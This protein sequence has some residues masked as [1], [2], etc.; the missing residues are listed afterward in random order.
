MD[1]QLKNKRSL[2]TGSTAGIG[3]AIAEALAREGAGV[4][5]N[6]RS[7]QSVDGAI[8]RLQPNVSGKLTGFAGDLSREDIAEKLA[9]EHPDIEILV[10]SL[11]IF[12]PVPFEQ[13]ADED[14]GASSRSMS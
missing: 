4:I 11:G 13:I 6:G 5:I 9:R 7:Q 3:F 10:N 14:W 2:V 12:E 8:D 1:L